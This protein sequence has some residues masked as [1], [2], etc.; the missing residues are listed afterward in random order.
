MGA[1]TQLQSLTQGTGTDLRSLIAVS[2]I[3]QHF[4]FYHFPLLSQASTVLFLFTLFKHL[5]FRHTYFVCFCLTQDIHMC[6][7]PVISVYVY[8]YILRAKFSTSGNWPSFIDMYIMLSHCQT[9]ADVCGLTDQLL[10]GGEI[11]EPEYGYIISKCNLFIYI[12]TNT[13]TQVVK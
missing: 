12:C 13:R 1:S 3:Q 7:Y 11:N 6:S 10:V 8:K 4:F 9:I 2:C 5:C